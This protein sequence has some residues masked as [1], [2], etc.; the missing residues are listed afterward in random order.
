M[1]ARLI[2]LLLLISGLTSPVY[3]YTGSPLD[4][5][6]D[7][8]S[9]S[10]QGLPIKGGGYRALAYDSINDSLYIGDKGV[11]KWDG[12]QFTIIAL[13][14]NN[15]NAL[16]W[17][18]QTNT[19]YAGG[20]FSIIDGQSISY[21]AKW[22]GSSWS[23]VGGGV[24]GPIWDL[25]VEPVSHKLYVG[26]S[27]TTAGGVTVNYIGTWDGTS[28]SA[29]GG[30]VNGGVS[31]IAW[32]PATSSL[33]VTGQM[34]GR[35]TKYNGSSWSVLGSGLDYGA[36]SLAWDT[37][38]NSLYVAGAY[39]LGNGVSC[40]GIG[41]FNGTTFTCLGTGFNLGVNSVEVGPSGQVFVG[42]RETTTKS[43]TTVNNIAKWNGSAFVAMANGLDG[44]IWGYNDLLWV[45]SKNTLYVVGDFNAANNGTVPAYRLVAWDNI[46]STWSSLGS[47]LDNVVSALAWDS[48]TGKL[49]VGGNFLRTPDGSTSYIAQWDGSRWNS[50]GSGVNGR[51]T[52][53]TW[54]A[55]TSTLYAG[56]TFATAGG[57]TVNKVAKWS[58][59]SWSALGS[60]AGVS[61]GSNGISSLAYDSASSSLYVGGDFT[62]AGGV[63]STKG[64]AKWNGSAWSALGTGISWSIMGGVYAAAMDSTSALYV[65][66]DF[67]A[68]G[69]KAKTGKIAKWSAGAWS[70]LAAI[71]PNNVVNALVVDPAT[72]NV[73]AGGAFTTFNGVSANYVAKWNGTSW[74]AL[75]TG[76]SGKVNAL[77]WDPATN[78]L[79][80]GGTFSTAGGISA[81][82]IAK[83]NGSAWSAVGASGVDA[84]VNALAF[85]SPQKILAT[86]GTFN[87]VDNVI[88]PLLAL[89][90]PLTGTWM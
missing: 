85:H 63:A 36:L 90:F 53:L 70:S 88:R 44:P 62:T 89:F 72:N 50:L 30:G 23:A 57:T 2:L 37:T 25:F 20:D 75:G 61:G 27:N 1:L 64:I 10:S 43:G 87:A 71:A 22:N 45:P 65:G 14:N 42:V 56:G 79:Y 7:I 35:I 73:Y 13:T 32:D 78:T 24:N 84:P 49:Y 31:A 69:G 11:A 77:A 76:T 3:S 51:V 80:V 52:A 8:P 48:S 12:K 21:L 28:W 58:E 19:L 33:Y 82:N 81:K 34:T 55:T 40:G 29:V 9:I 38:T 41:K 15:V 86:G 47:G 6:M 66:G 26:G 5:G 18:P 54:D 68:A 59:G 67:T 83:W 17:D 4:F 60:T 74:S 46:S 39:T 16:A